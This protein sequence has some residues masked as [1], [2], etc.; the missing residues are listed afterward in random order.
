[1]E[2]TNKPQLTKNL[3]WKILI[4]ITKWLT[5]RS[6]RIEVVNAE[7]IRYQQGVVI[8]ANH[9]S[10]FDSFPLAIAIVHLGRLPRFLARAEIFSYPIFGAMA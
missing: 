10:W 7:Y 4:P 2:L 1:M 8:A 9:I 3:L 6:T 5:H